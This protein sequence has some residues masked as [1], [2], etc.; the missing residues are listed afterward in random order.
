[1]YCEGIWP[2]ARQRFGKHRL[3][4]GITKEH[5]LS[6]GSSRLLWQRIT[7]NNR[8]TVWDGDLYSGRL[9]VT[10]N[11]DSVIREFTP[12][13]GGIEYLHRDPASRRRRWKGKSQ[14]WD[15]KIWPWVSRD[16][17]PRQTALAKGQQHIQKTDP[18]SRQRG[19][20]TKQ[21]RNYQTVINIYSWAPD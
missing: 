3:K 7:Q 6:N 20:T 2:F 11:S 19:R 15:C 9:E 17:D 21:D 10:K 1:M 18:S 4:T 12:C 5:L 8:G 14:I 16:W 13:G